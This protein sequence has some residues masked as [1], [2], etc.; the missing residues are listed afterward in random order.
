MK[1]FW[2]RFEKRCSH[3]TPLRNSD[4][5]ETAS[6]ELEQEATKASAYAAE[7]ASIRQE[8]SE[9]IPAF[10]FTHPR[11][12][13]LK[14]KLKPSLATPTQSANTV[15]DEID[16]ILFSPGAPTQE[17]SPQLPKVSPTKQAA[18]RESTPSRR[19]RQRRAQE[20]IREKESACRNVR[21]F[22]TESVR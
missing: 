8:K 12:D 9:P 16:E 5:L 15:G 4:A 14:E 17:S 1:E 21:F 19:R 11:R 7:R 20:V 13:H 18:S 2:N 3:Y 6:T 22:T 10:D